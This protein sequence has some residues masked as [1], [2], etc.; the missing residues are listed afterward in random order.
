MAEDLD[1]AKLLHPLIRCALAL[2]L[3]VGLSACSLIQ[4]QD[5]LTINVIGIDPLPGQ[6]L[7]LRMA[8][9]LRVQ[10]PNDQNLEFKGVALKLQI[11]DQPFATGVSDQHGHIGSYSEH[12]ITVPMTVTAFAFLRQA[13]GMTQLTSLQGLPYVISGKLATGTIG[14][15]RFE[16][17]GRL[18]LPRTFG[19]PLVPFR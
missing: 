3:A 17:K 18:D 4:P 19:Q 13:Y 14:A 16:Y 1:M 15:V 11:N 7:E 10:N 9:K 5:P 12:V 6:D 2:A 8:V